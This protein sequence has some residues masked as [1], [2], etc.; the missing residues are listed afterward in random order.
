MED[1]DSA[2]A[3][4]AEKMKEKFVKYWGSPEKMNKLFFIASILD[5][6]NNRA[7]VRDALVDMYGK[8]KGSK[9][10]G[11]VETYMK[12]LFQECKKKL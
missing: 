11:E 4:M 2:L 10:R 7:Y 12:S 6:R 1:D 5:P 9:I 8:E 3:K